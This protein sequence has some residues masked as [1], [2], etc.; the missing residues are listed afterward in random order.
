MWNRPSKMKEGFVIGG[1]LMIVGIVLQLC[2]GP[3]AWEL[4]AWSVNGILMAAFLVIIAIAYLLRKRL[5]VLQ[6]VGSYKAAIPAL[7]YAVALTIVMGLVPQKQN[8]GWFS[9]MLGFWPFVLIYVY[10]ALILGLSVIG[11]MM[12]FSWKRD[13]PFLL[14]HLGLFVAM[15][16]AT[17]GSADV[18]RLK[19]ITIEGLPEWRAIDAKG[20][21]KEMPVAIELEKFIMDTYDDGSPKRFA[22]QIKIQTK[23]GENIK[24]TIDV[25]NPFEIEG[26]KIYQYSYETSMDGENNIS[27]LELVSDP[28]LPLVYAG[29][30]MMLAGAACLLLTSKLKWGY[31]GTIGAVGVVASYFM[32]RSLHAK[33]LMPALQSPWFAP[34]VIVYMFCYGVFGVATV[35]A[36]YDLIK[37]KPAN[38]S[39]TNLVY[40]GTGLMTVGMLFGALWA[41]EAWGHYWN[42]DPKETWAAITWFAYLIYIHYRRLPNCNQRLALWVLVISFVLL[43]MCWWGINYLPSAQ[44]M[45][46][47][48]YN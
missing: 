42:W 28:W 45:S 34:H 32:L 12:H 4:V 46:V 21:I 8:Q 24:A 11:R 14:N 1:G 23:Q 38:K 10:V 20:L 16:A 33:P 37:R 44:G 31:I 3:V 15:V 40:V 6:F 5:G 35:M 2:L 43:Q 18:Q 26:W 29:F 47:H 7:A 39:I 30:F 25:N 19:M 27:I 17:L 36:I 48:T 41:K 13:V 9:Y 22:S